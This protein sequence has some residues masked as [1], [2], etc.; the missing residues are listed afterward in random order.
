MNH[1]SRAGTGSGLS[2]QLPLGP[3][4]SPTPTLPIPTLAAR[5]GDLRQDFAR[6]GRAFQDLFGGPT[7][8]PGSAT[9]FVFAP[10]RVNLFGGHL[11]YNGGPV[12]PTAIDRGTFIAFRARRD[13]RVVLASTF[14]PARCELDLDD[15]PGARTGLWADY[16]LG[17]LREL[18]ARMPA[19]RGPSAGGLDVLFGGNLPVGAGLSSSASICVGTAHALDLAWTLGLTI[20]ERVAAALTAERGFVGVQCGIMDP[21]AVGLAKPGHVLWLDCKDGT[22]THLPLDFAQL[23]IGVVDTGVERQLAR[24][25]F[26]RRVDE[27]RRA[28]AVLAPHA[29]GATVLRDV[30][31]AVVEA[32]ANELDAVLLRRARHVVQEVERTFAARRALETGDVRALGALMSATHV[33][34]RDLYECSCQELDVLVA[35][36]S[37]Q[38]G[39]LGARL[40]GAGFGGCIVMLVEAGREDEVLEAVQ[41]RFEARFGRRPLAGFFRGDEGPREIAL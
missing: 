2:S 21:Y 19:K 4:S 6:H 30:P 13:R 12:M 29:P 24:S 22:H 39:C 10:G 38:A 7:A 32:H 8:G 41:E 18:A 27:C 5:V 23:S 34:L 40:T 37:A 33:S 26:N 9:R 25:E 36:A 28:F 17:V 16:P 31:S 35:A 3:M 11:D 15:L 20:Q 14:E 1:D